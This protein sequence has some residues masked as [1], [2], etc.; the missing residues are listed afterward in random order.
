[1]FGPWLAWL[2]LFSRSVSDLRRQQSPLGISAGG[3]YF[4][5]VAIDSAL[6]ALSLV[7]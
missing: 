4:I 7:L 3:G 5:G 2:E 1:M 6:V